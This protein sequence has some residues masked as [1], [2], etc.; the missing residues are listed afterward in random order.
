[1]DSAGGAAFTL[2]VIFLSDD[3]YFFMLSLVRSLPWYSPVN[4]WRK[5][6]TFCASSGYISRAT[7]NLAIFVMAKFSVWTLPSW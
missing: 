7:W 5:L 6:S 4:A 2:C 3:F 1:M